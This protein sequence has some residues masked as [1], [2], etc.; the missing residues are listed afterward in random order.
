MKN[1]KIAKQKTQDEYDEITLEIKKVLE[2][3]RANFFG[4][5]SS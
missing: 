4:R 3:A 2:L 1:Y 5:Q